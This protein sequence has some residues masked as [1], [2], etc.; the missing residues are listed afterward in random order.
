MPPDPLGF[1]FSIIMI[2][3]VYL[4]VKGRMHKPFQI[5]GIFFVAYFIS[6]VGHY[7]IDQIPK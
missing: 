5:T 4:A 7:I 1:L 2:L 3:L 6:E